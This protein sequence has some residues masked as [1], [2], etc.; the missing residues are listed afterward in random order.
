VC[1]VYVVCVWVCVCVCVKCVCVWVS[2]Y[3]QRKKHNCWQRSMR[4]IN[5]THER[6]AL[7]VR[8]NVTNDPSCSSGTT[9]FLHYRYHR[10]VSFREI[11]SA[12]KLAV[13]ENTELLSVSWCL[14]CRTVARMVQRVNNLDWSDYSVN[15]TTTFACRNVLDCQRGDVWDDTKQKLEVSGHRSHWLTQDKWAGLRKCT[16]PRG[17]SYFRS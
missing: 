1:G 8:V 7:I 14:T 13:W 4:A 3:W 12:F 2:W 5:N 6:S 15:L 9:F 11:I 16:K 10:A 17:S